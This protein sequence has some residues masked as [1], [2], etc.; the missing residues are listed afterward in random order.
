MKV[1]IL[2]EFDVEG[3]DDE[4]VA[5]TAAA[6]AA[7]DYLCFCTAA[8]VTAGYEECSVHVDGHGEM[9]VKMGVEHG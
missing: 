1:K 2:V 9:S 6:T 8:G 3:T 4:K 5:K 7:W